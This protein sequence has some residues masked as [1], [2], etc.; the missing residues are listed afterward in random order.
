MWRKIRIAILLLILIFVALKTW[1]DRLYTT[2]W[3]APLRVTVQPINADGSD[4]TQRHIEKMSGEKFAP[5]ETFF[6]QEGEHYDIKLD[7]PIRVTLL[8]A[9]QSRPPQIGAH[10]GISAIMLW[11][12]KLRYWAWR[13]GDSTQRPQPDVRL[14]LLYFDPARTSSL[15]HSIGLQKGLVG[16][17]N[18]FADA[19]VDATNNVI[20]AHEL[21]HTLGATDKYGPDNLPHF[22]DG[23]AEP[24]RE[25]RFP[26]RFAELMGGRTALSETQA[27]TPHSL[28]EVLLGPLTAH[29]I[30]WSK[31]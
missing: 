20:I 29:E 19:R 14:F 2:D 8:G 26:Q 4:V 12:L 24:E 30:G 11:S 16:L 1:T 31:H 28:D 5:I 17:V 10:A 21:L 7:R 25:P 27:E 13:H 15:H 6:S 23:F 9:V 18:V 3:N 22:P